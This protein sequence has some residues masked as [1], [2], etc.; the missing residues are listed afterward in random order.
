MIEALA[1]LLLCQLT[2]EILSHGLGLPMPGPVIGLLIL[3]A[4][5]IAA[6]NFG[7]VAASSITDT[8]LG[9][10]TGGLLQHLSVLFVPAGVGV[11]DHLHLLKTYG[12]VLILALFISTVLSLAVTGLTFTAVKGWQSARKTS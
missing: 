2:G 12:P 3:C 11:I 10:A 7:K 8:P 1:L 4:L 9:R 6:Q 5:L